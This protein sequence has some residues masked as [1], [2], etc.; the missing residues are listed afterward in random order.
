MSYPLLELSFGDGRD[1][2]YNRDAPARASRTEMRAFEAPADDLAL[3]DRIRAGDSGALGVLYERTF[4]DLWVFAR[5]Y[6]DESRAEEIVQDVFLKFWARRDWVISTTPRA[7]LFGAVRHHA[8]NVMHRDVIEA[9]SAEV[10]RRDVETHADDGGIDLELH[11]LLANTVAAF[12]ER[13]RAAI[14]LRIERELSYREVGDALGISATAAG[15]LI[16]K[17]EDKLR[18]VLGDW[19][20]RRP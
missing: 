12:P 17:A 4:R 3:V 10:L 1:R 20:A 11:T 7:Y 14:V 2:E 8:L 19:A 18:R 16:K 13:Q 9:R 15:N 5:R 6:V